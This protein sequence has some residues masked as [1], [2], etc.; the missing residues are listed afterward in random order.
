MNVYTNENLLRSLYKA[1]F[2][3]NTD[4]FINLE[5]PFDKFLYTVDG[6]L[7]VSNYKLKEAV[8]LNQVAS[9]GFLC[10]PDV[11]MPYE[12]HIETLKAY[13]KVRSKPRYQLDVEEEEILYE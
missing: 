1:G 13:T 4:E 3:I 6:Q 12:L 10:A 5:L 7:G 9:V 11:S 8:H 2:T